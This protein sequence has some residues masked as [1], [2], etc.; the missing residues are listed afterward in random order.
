[1]DEAT[2]RQI[3][4]E[5]FRKIKEEQLPEVLTLNLACEY[6]QVSDTWLKDNLEIRNIP[7]FRTGSHYKFN[8]S[9]LREWTR[10][11]NEAKAKAAKTK[12]NPINRKNSGIMRV[13]L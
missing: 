4:S 1:M 13:S 11:E 10:R 7:Y 3:I 6:L 8:L 5:E 2:L 12:F 9:E